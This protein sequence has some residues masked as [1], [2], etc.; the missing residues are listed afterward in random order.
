MQA[1]NVQKKHNLNVESVRDG[2]FDINGAGIFLKKIVCFP[3][4]VKIIKNV[5]NKVK[6]KK[7]VLHSVI[8]FQSPFPWEL[9]RFANS[10]E[11]KMY[12]A[13]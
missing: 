12:K 13:C 10:T 7:F 6:N 4:G 11:F 8:F 9:L 1:Y 3:I 5:F 2:P